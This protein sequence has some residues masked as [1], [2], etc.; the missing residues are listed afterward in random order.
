MTQYAV[1]P[2]RNVSGKPGKW[3]ELLM[4]YDL[5][6][7]SAADSNIKPPWSPMGLVP[8]TLV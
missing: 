7:F 4:V 5:A 2:V 3:G 1:E 8:V 6:R